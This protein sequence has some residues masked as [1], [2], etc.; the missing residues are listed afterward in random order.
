MVSDGKYASLLLNNGSLNVKTH[1]QDFARLKLKLGDLLSRILA[2]W[3]L[4]LKKQKKR[5]KANGSTVSIPQDGRN[6][7][8]I[9]MFYLSNTINKKSVKY[10][11]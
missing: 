1:F 6:N 8:S 9:T 4:S 3:L 2:S 7:V 11:K 5:K 10:F